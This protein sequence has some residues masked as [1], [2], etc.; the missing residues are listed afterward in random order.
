MIEKSKTVKNISHSW[1]VEIDGSVFLM[2][3]MKNKSNDGHDTCAIPLQVDKSMQSLFK[4]FDDVSIET[5][6][7][8]S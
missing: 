2:F 7:W 6:G 8:K 5:E 1:V 3:S 4:L